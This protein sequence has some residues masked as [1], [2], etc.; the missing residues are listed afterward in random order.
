MIIIIFL[1]FFLGL[2][3]IKVYAPSKKDRY[4]FNNDTINNQK[5]LNVTN[6][7]K[8]INELKRDSI[9]WPLPSDI[10]Y[11]PIMTGKDTEAFLLS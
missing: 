5:E 10:I 6:F 11:K 4:F 1:L 8:R 9:I 7:E 3:K 2:L